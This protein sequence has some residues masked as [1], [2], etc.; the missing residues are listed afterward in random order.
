MFCTVSLQTFPTLLS[1]LVMLYPSGSEV[2][3]DLVC[4]FLHGLIS[5]GEYTAEMRNLIQSFPPEVKESAELSSLM[6]M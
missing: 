2:C 4:A 6:T 1:S 3:R 5:R